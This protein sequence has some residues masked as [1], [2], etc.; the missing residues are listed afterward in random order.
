[1]ISKFRA[2]LKAKGGFTLVE[3]MTA[4]T[5]FSLLSFSGLSLVTTA[6]NSWNRDVTRATLENE[7]GHTMRRVVDVLRSSVSVVVDTNGQGL[8]YYL[9]LKSGGRV[10]L[11]L[12]TD[13][14]ARRIWRSTDGKKLYMT[15]Y[16]RPFS[17]YL[18]PGSTSNVLFALR[19]SG[20]A[21][22]VTLASSY[23]NGRETL[24]TSKSEVVRL[25]NIQ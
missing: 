13:G 16:T 22:V 7:T 19:P 25:R 1:M 23:N 8:T 4:V 11:P 5:I 15:G 21:V 18:T 9:P 24:A 2:H 10:V 3:S 14:V 20:K 6:I 17:K 12:Q